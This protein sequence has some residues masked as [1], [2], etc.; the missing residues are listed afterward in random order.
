MG[1]YQ[2]KLCG[3]T[4]RINKDESFA[5]CEYCDTKQ[6]I[7]KSNDSNNIK[8]HNEANSL[9]LVN[10]FDDALLMY[11]MILSNEYADAEAHWGVVLSK[12]GIEYV[13]DP[14][15]GKRIPTC[16][17][18]VETSIFDDINYI[19]ALNNADVIAKSLYEEEAKVIDNLQKQIKKIASKE[20][21]YDI[22]ISFKELDENGD[23]TRD[24]YRAQELYQALTE[25][26]YRVFYSKISL[27]D[28]IGTEYEP[29]IYSA[30]KSAKIMVV[31]GSKKEYFNSVWVKNEWNRYLSFI[32]RGKNYIVPLYS[33]MD[34]YDLP[35]ELL[36]F[37]ALNM[38]KLGWDLDFF[39]FVDKLFRNN[40]TQRNEEKKENPALK[41]IKFYLDECEFERAEELAEKFVSKN[42]G[43]AEGYFYLCLAQNELSEDFLGEGWDWYLGVDSRFL[44]NSNFKLALSLAQGEFREKLVEYAADYKS[45]IMYFIAKT[46]I[47]NSVVFPSELIDEDKPMYDQ[48]SDFVSLL[49]YYNIINDDVC[50][51]CNNGV[52]DELLVPIVNFILEGNSESFD[53]IH[54]KFS[55]NFNRY[56]TIM[57][58]LTWC[59]LAEYNEIDHTYHL[60]LSAD[61]AVEKIESCGLMNSEKRV[62]NWTVID[63][64][65]IA[66]AIYNDLEIPNLSN[67]EYPFEF[68]RMKMKKILVINNTGEDEGT[69]EFFME[70]SKLFNIRSDRFL[71]F[72]SN[73][74]PELEIKIKNVSRKIKIKIYET[75]IIELFINEQGEISYELT[76]GSS[77]E[78]LNELLTKYF[79][80]EKYAVAMEIAKQIDS[81]Y[82]SSFDLYKKLLFIDFE[83]QNYK[84]LIDIGISI[85]DNDYF[86]AAIEIASDDE[87]TELIEVA[88]MI[89]ELYGN[90]DDYDEGAIDN[91]EDYVEEDFSEEQDIEE[92]VY[93]EM[94]FVIFNDK[95][96]VKKLRKFMKKS[97]QE[98]VFD[99]FLEEI[100]KYNNMLDGHKYTNKTALR[101]ISKLSDPDL[102]PNFRESYQWEMEQLKK[103]W[104]SEEI[105]K[106]TVKM[107]EYLNKMKTKIGN[108]I[109]AFKDKN[110]DLALFMNNLIRKIK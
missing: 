96:A 61:N 101:L 3:G 107:N 30:L 108:K 39:S 48:V 56:N 28:K 72:L 1:I 86:N 75:N 55:I 53:S 42:I 35:K 99:E 103:H 83:V 110:T 54:K 24:S 62:T 36:S 82:G 109:K 68:N 40:K 14:E 93:D 94:D 95:K 21:P 29:I 31:I 2:C 76:D 5:I 67:L 8:L 33:N 70:N 87:K 22:F 49:S 92:T 90:E 77:L 6:T 79:E 34:A 46:I 104:G 98:L 19:E 45:R 84:E 66:L 58:T 71:T 25:K 23:R 63:I 97:G 89:E 60:T 37:Q 102:N 74:V 50:H 80:D 20:D 44:D 17:R 11:R 41:V 4:L 100:N 57:R 81:N 91:E 73:D 88:D 18:T 26:G 52:N 64:D 47:H 32:E 43:N 69:L 15:T 106:D 105:L 9:R 16:H 12:F 85:Y 10:N 65:D 78:G 27:E 59:E 13:E 38:D 51:S 7:P